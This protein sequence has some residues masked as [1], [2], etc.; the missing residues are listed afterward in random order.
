MVAQRIVRDL[1]SREPGSSEYILDPWG[2]QYTSHEDGVVF[3]WSGAQFDTLLWFGAG[4]GDHWRVPDGGG[5]YRFLVNDTATVTV[6]GVPLRRSAISMIQLGDQTVIALDTLYE[7]IGF[8]HLDSFVPLGVLADGISI[9]FLCYGD[10]DL[11]FTKPGVMD[12]GF[13]VNVEEAALANELR[14]WPNPG[15]DVLHIETGRAGWAD[16]RVLDGVGQAVFM[17]SSP[18]GSFVL[19][20]S[21]LAPGIYLVEMNS[22][23]GRRTEKWMKR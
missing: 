17:A 15:S 1:Y 18:N 19:D 7:R 11:S 22:I 12:C 10:Q 16:V 14:I 21:S 23:A 3:R 13:T 6:D 5:G 9:R 20:G 4:P 2:V 8:I